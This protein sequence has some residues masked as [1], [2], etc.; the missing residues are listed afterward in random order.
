MCKSTRLPKRKHMVSPSTLHMSNTKQTVDIMDILT[1]RVMPIVRRLFKSL[2]L[3]CRSSCIADIKN[4][5]T[6]AAQMDGAIIMSTVI[7]FLIFVTT[8]LHLKVVSTMDGQ[9]P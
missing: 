1:V 4:M 3:L 5:V 6:G 2:S 7:H 9:M 8:A